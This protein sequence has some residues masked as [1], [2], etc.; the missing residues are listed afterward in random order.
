MK[1][2]KPPR[3][4]V[5]QDIRIVTAALKPEATAEVG[6]NSVAVAGL[7]G[8]AQAGVAATAIA[9]VRG[10]A[11]VGN[12]GIAICGDGGTATSGA[13]GYSIAYDDGTAIA[14]GGDGGVAITRLRGNA[15]VNGRWGIAVAQND[16]QATLNEQWGV[17]IAM[18]GGSVSG[19]HG[20]LLVAKYLDEKEGEYRFAVG[21][22]G[23]NGIKANRRYV[24]GSN[25]D[26]KLA[27]AK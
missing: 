26:L 7:D 2:P 22:V 11:T 1:H 21:V 5:S 16:G 25:G 14:A 15:M 9:G 6:N 18:N 10:K 8:T 13:N 27:C 12:Y 23:Q 17:A 24:A 3:L 19:S 4:K 20:C